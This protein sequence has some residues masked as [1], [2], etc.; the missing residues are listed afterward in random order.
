M[1]HFFKLCLI[2]L[3]FNLLHLPVHAD[4]FYYPWEYNALYNEKVALELE[5]KSLKRQFKNEVDNL[6]SKI[7]ELENEIESL[8]K[9]LVLAEKSRK[10]DNRLSENRINELKKIIEILK[11]K[12]SDREKKL[13]T[14]NKKMQ[15]DCQLT[16][17][18]L[19]EEQQRERKANIEELAK[20]KKAYENEI[21]KL[22]KQIANLN[23]DLTTIKKLSDAR[24]QELDRMSQQANELE[25]QLADEIKN[26][27]IRLKR[28]HE[29][30]I[31]NI[32]D[33]ISFDSGSAKLKDSV[34]KALDKISEILSKY[35]ENRII[36]E[37]HTD[38]IPIK[39][40]YF[41]DNWHLSIERALAVLRYLL[42][43]TGLDPIRVS[44]AGYGEYH[45][46]VSNDT[47]DNR[48][49][50]RRVDIVVVPRVKSK[51]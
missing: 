15:E 9:E 49:F 38:N 5:L 27:E 51:K 17:E 43:N 41:K 40:G 22:K 46:I 7:M 2:F 26:G 16:V 1:G 12:G 3:L 20:L 37:G 14:E 47:A 36:I 18:N 31:I 35:S 44:G 11:K 33:K 10:E 48:A 21:G 45:P 42:T 23:E 24:K 8:N 6:Q 28:L 13:L 30:I 19:R 29:K 25:N 4:V 50:N 39:A 34:L 32:D